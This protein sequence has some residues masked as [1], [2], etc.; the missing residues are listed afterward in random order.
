MNQCLSA[1]GTVAMLPMLR[2]IVLWNVFKLEVLSLVIV[3]EAE[4]V[5]HDSL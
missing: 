1:M 2:L 4:E 3:D 5:G